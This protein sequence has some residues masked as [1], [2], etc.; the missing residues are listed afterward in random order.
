VGFVVD[1]MALGQVFSEYFGFPCQ[2]SFHQLLHNHPPLSFGLYNRPEVAAIPGDVGPTPL[3]K[4]SHVTLGLPNSDCCIIILHVIT[5]TVCIF[6]YVLCARTVH[7][8]MCNPSYRSF[9]K[10]SF[11]FL[12][13][14]TQ[15]LAS[16]NLSLDFFQVR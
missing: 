14:E 5:R 3:K 10:I 2:S 4:I 6:S 7:I 8:G 13:R 1:K 11:L 15:S 9:I 16:R 12:L